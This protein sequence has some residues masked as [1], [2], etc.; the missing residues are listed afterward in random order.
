MER[1]SAALAIPDKHTCVQGTITTGMEAL[2]VLLR[3]LS[4]PNRICDLAQLFGNLQSE[5]SFI[6]NTVRFFNIQN[7]CIHVYIY[8][9]MTQILLSCRS[10]MTYM[11]DSVTY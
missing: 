4:Y 10:S 1:L 11:I 2:M 7:K 8:V 6:F 5:L 9:Y 3:R